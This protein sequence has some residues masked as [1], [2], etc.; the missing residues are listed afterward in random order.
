VLLGGAATPPALLTRARDAGARVVTTYG[1]SET[2]GGC[3]YDGVPLDGVRVR[4][5]PDGAIE[6]A[7]PVLATGY[8]DRPDLDAR[9]F[10]VDGVDGV[11]GDDGA[12]RWL[13]T[14]DL[15][16]LDAGR[17]TVL[18]RA[19]DVLVTGGVKVPPA[20]VERVLAEL[21][22]VGEVC[23]VGVPDAEWGQ[24][25]VAVV[26]PRD[27]RT[28][29]ALAEVRERVARTLGAPAAPR[30]VLVVER[31]PLRGPGKVDRRAVTDLAAARLARRATA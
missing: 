21:P 9:T 24:A 4:L 1:M 10:L 29:P 25:V 13:R 3:V 23:V 7:G 18:G 26:V 20:A 15:G 17:L 11:D 19:D 16:R 6:I 22:D 30:H 14:R 5:S 12:V 31:L 2:C 8:L 28:G 27:G